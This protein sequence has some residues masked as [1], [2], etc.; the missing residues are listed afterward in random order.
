MLISEA[1]WIVPGYW[2]G[3]A[4]KFPSGRQKAYAINP[5]TNP[6]MTLKFIDRPHQHVNM[7][8]SFWDYDIPKAIT[9]NVE[10]KR[11]GHLKFAGPVHLDQGWNEWA[12]DEGFE[13]DELTLEVQEKA[14]TDKDLLIIDK[15]S[16]YVGR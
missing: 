8:L 2:F 3:P 1:G 6:K 10:A 13:F 14:D 4:W 7:T 12:F 15:L 9:M 5:T 16:F 11:E